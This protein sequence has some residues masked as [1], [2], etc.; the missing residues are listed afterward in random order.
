MQ[1]TSPSDSLCSM[2][3]YYV[4]YLLPLL[5]VQPAIKSIA[6]IAIAANGKGHL[7]NDLGNID[8]VENNSF[9]TDDQMANTKSTIVQCQMSIDGT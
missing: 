9:S 1:H 5:I 3:L 7:S 8:I 4:P 6:D 2:L